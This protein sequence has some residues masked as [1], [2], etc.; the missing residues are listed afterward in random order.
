MELKKLVGCEIN[1]SCI[2]LA[3]QLKKALKY[4]V[5]KRPSDITST[6]HKLDYI[7]GEIQLMDNW[8]GPNFNMLMR[9]VSHNIIG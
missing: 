9:F 1:Y 3:Y 5:I 6:L 8:L 2:L 7:Y 4:K